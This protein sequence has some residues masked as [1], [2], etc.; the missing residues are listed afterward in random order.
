MCMNQHSHT[1]LLDGINFLDAHF[2]IRKLFLKAYT[3][4]LSNFT[5]RH[6]PKE[7]IG[8]VRE[9]LSIHFLLP[10]SS[11]PEKQILQSHCLKLLSMKGYFCRDFLSLSH[12]QS[13]AKIIKTFSFAGS[14]FFFSIFSLIHFLFPSLF[15]V[16]S[17]LPLLPQQGKKAGM[18]WQGCQGWGA[19]L[20]GGLNWPGALSVSSL[21]SDLPFLPMLPLPG[22]IFF[23]VVVVYF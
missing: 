15:L 8:E 22:P 16:S 14:F 9:A 6:Y 13:S 5:I 12:F 21:T 2:V 19:W 7:R 23:V 11:S 1:F 17:C 18:R 20:E 3:I 4:R 10:V